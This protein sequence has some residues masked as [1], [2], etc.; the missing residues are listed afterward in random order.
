[1]EKDTKEKTK[2]AKIKMEKDNKKEAKT[3]VE[4]EKKTKAE[5]KTKKA[6]AAK[7]KAEAAKKKKEE[8]AEK[9]RAALEKEIVKSGISTVSNLPCNS[10]AG[11][12][13]FGY[14]L[15]CYSRVLRT[16]AV[17][18]LAQCKVD[19]TRRHDCHIAEWN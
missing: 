6:D 18:T 16:G 15:K 8:A 10:D 11:P 19:C 9:V 1:M 5:E 4:N 7:K 14:N 13:C 3:K 17:M 12:I 2:K